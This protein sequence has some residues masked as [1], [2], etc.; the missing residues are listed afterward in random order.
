MTSLEWSIRQFTDSL[1][2]EALEPFRRFNEIYPLFAEYAL[3]GLKRFADYLAMT[4]RP[5]LFK[6]LGS[7]PGLGGFR[8]LRDPLLSAYSY[9]LRVDRDE[10]RHVFAEQTE[11]F[12]RLAG[13]DGGDESEF[14][15]RSRIEHRTVVFIAAG[16]ITSEGTTAELGYYQPGQPP[17]PLNLTEEL[18]EVIEQMCDFLTQLHVVLKW[19]DGYEPMDC[20]VIPG[21]GE[22]ATTYWPP[23]D[24]ERH[25]DTKE[26]TSSV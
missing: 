7:A 3:V 13:H 24:P 2:D 21:H 18:R 25:L 1:A 10:I 20:L 15:I 4:V 14:G 22:Q 17:Q 6:K 12:D 9:P 8:S 16:S 5:L 26:A 19:G 23:I 11:W